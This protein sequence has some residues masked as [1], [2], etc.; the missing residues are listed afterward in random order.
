MNETLNEL[1]AALRERLEIIGDEESRRDPKRH[2]QRLQEVSE[3]LEQLERQLPAG[4]HPQLRHFLE[5]RSYVKALELVEA[6]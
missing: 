5:R 2:M 3:R 6:T 4:T 1:A